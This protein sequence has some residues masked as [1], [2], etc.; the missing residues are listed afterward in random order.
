MFKLR[1]KKVFTSITIL[2]SA[3]EYVK[4]AAITMKTQRQIKKFLIL[5][6][7]VST[8]LFFLAADKYMN[9]ISELYTVL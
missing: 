5:D 3:I 4:T 8:E 2:P 1:V 6:G 7:E 9:N